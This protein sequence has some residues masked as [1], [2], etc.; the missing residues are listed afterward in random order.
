M[1]VSRIPHTNYLNICER[2]YDS[3][4]GFFHFCLKS[5]SV[6]SILDSK[7]IKPVNPKG[8][9][10]WIFTGRTDVETESPVLWPT[11]AKSQIIGKDPNARKDWRHGNKGAIKDEMVG[12]H[13]WLK[14][15]KFEQMLGASEGQG[16]L[17]CCSPWGCKEWDMTWQLSNNKKEHLGACEKDP[18]SGPVSEERHRVKK[19]S[20]PDV[21]PSMAIELSHFVPFGDL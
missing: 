6:R 17:M 3:F 14:G 4:V 7:E 15:H 2:L 13:H 1:F 21:V 20:Q 10:S 16:S 19:T 8:N 5:I 9:Q 12:W 18:K 11:D